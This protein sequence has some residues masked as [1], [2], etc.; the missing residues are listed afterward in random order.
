MRTDDRI[1]MLREQRLSPEPPRANGFLAGVAS[2]VRE[3]AEISLEN[4]RHSAREEART[5]GRRTI[6]TAALLVALGFGIVMI[7]V[8]AGQILETFFPTKGTGY[9]ILGGFFALA[10]G[11]AIALT[12]RSRH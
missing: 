1:Q 5:L 3:L 6:I 2:Y 10:S 7:G 12:L 4:V 8:G 9:L 11:I